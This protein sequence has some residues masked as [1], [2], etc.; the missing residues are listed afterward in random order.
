MNIRAPV[1]RDERPAREECLQEASLRGLLGPCIAATCKHGLVQTVTFYT[2][3][4]ATPTLAQTGLL[5]L[6]AAGLDA[7]L[8][9]VRLRRRFP[10][11][12]EV[13]NG[14]IALS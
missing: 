5:K 10:A 2:N 12:N 11:A 8:A 6:F 3:A 7:E 13:P 9:H 14:P 4:P 1:R